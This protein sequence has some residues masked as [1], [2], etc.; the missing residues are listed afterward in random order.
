MPT[1][2]NEKE[3]NKILEDSLQ[4][5]ISKFINS[6]VEGKTW[7]IIEFKE[8]CC[9]NRDRRWVVKFILEPFKDEI[10]YRAEN[11][12]GWCIYAK[13][14]QI[15]AKLATK[16]MEKNFSRIDWDAKLPIKG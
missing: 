10:E 15:R 7:S 11:R 6:Q 9:F 16:W 13:S 14:Y 3:I 1:L 8:A 2:I 12:D 5:A 4:D